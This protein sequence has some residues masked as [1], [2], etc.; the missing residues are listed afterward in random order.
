MGVAPI[1]GSHEGTWGLGPPRI[2]GFDRDWPDFFVGEAR[3]PEGGADACVAL[4]WVLYRGGLQFPFALRW[5]TIEP[6]TS[7]LQNSQ[8]VAGTPVVRQVAGFY[9]LCRHIE[10]NRW[11][12]P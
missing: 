4:V 3:H 12:L 11:P 9:G 6:D 2:P 5:P 1:V 10:W 7:V 8:I